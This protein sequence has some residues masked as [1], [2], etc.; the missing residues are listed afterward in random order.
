M[1]SLIVVVFLT[2][3]SFLLSEINIDLCY[4]KKVFSIDPGTIH[5]FLKNSG[6]EE[7]YIDKVYFNGK[8]IEEGEYTDE[9]YWW[10]QIPNTIPPGGI[11][12]LM[13]KVKKI[14][15][16]PLTIK[17]KLSNGGTLEKIFE[18]IVP[19]FFR[20]T[21]VKFNLNE[22]KVYIYIENKFPYKVLKIKKIFIN[23][24]DATGE[25]KKPPYILPLKKTLIV[26]KSAEKLIPGEYLYIKI[27]SEE[28]PSM[29]EIIAGTFV[30]IYDYFPIQSFGKDNRKE[31][32][33][34]PDNFDIH[35]PRDIKKFEEYRK[36]PYYKVYHLLDDPVCRDEK[37][38]FLGAMVK[39]V[40]K[41]RKICWE[42]DRKHSTIIYICEYC[43]PLGYF[44]YGELVD[45]VAVDPYQLTYYNSPPEEDGC[46][47]GL[48]KLAS[49]PRK[50]ISIP[51][52][53]KYITQKFPKGSK[54]YPTPE[55][56]RLIVY[57]EIANGATGLWYFTSSQ[58]YGYR[59]SP[60]LEKEISSINKEMQLLK[61]FLNIGEPI[62]IAKTD[63]QSVKADAILCGDKGIVI[64]LRNGDYRTTF[65]KEKKIWETKIENPGR[66]KIILTLNLPF[67]CYIRSI[68]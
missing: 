59:G 33:F 62:N 60:R 45:I 39:E 64:I 31:M 37:K 41:R 56:E 28:E 67:P 54:R 48:A 50:I 53:F 55:E 38:G 27:L 2:L 34:N 17:I 63:S 7:V 36:L 32:F 10:T 13:I 47:V 16:I 21:S 6:N 4:Y 43:K 1:R 29:E 49:Q 35:F 19:E 9:I 40:I 30:R 57:S 26:Y 20:I 51:E 58:K 18:S 44:V 8:E 25:V 15:S 61:N 68:Y 23:C 3:S 52:A 5:F 14:P 42:K 11:G 24:K 12:N 65:N 66:F 22:N 46:F